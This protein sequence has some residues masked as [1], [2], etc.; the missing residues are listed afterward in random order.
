MQKHSLVTTHLWSRSYKTST[1]SEGAFLV[2]FLSDTFRE[3]YAETFQYSSTFN[4]PSRL[5]RKSGTLH[6]I[7][8]PPN[9]MKR[10]AS[11]FFS[12]SLSL[13]K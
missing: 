5:T 8:I 12:L 10:F 2:G 7:D 1:T 11:S 9:R 13:V 4:V 3:V 6:A